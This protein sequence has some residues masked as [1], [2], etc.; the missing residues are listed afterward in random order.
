MFIHLKNIADALQEYNP[1]LH[2]PAP[3]FCISGYAA[4]RRAKRPLTPH[5]LYIAFNWQQA[6]EAGLTPCSNVVILEKSDTTV[7]DLSELLGAKVNFILIRTDHAQDVYH[8][9]EDFFFDICS[10]GVFSDS[11]LHSLFEETGIQSMI[12]QT[13]P[14]FGNPIMVFDTGFHLIAATWQEARK[15][16]YGQEI[17]EQGKLPDHLYTLLNHNNHFHERMRKS[18]VPLKTYFPELGFEQML[19]AIDTQKNM[20]Y[21]VI[22]AVNRPFAPLDAP[23]LYLLKEAINQQM[24]KD[25]FIRNSKGF[26]YEY[27]LKDLLDGKIAVDKDNLDTFN[28]TSSEFQGLLYCLTVETARSASTLN[29]WHIRNEFEIHFPSCKT[30]IYNGEIIVLFTKS[31]YVPFTDEDY[32]KIHA[33]CKEHG[34]YA[35]ISNSF[36]QVTEIHSYYSQSL[37]AIEIGMCQRTSPGLFIYEDY[38]QQHLATIFAQKESLQ[39]FCHPIMKYLMRYDGEHHTDFACSLYTYLIHERN[40]SA[41]AEDLGLHR[42][43]LVYRLKKLEEL[44][45]I[46][47]EDPKLRQYLILSYQM[48]HPS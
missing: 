19:C 31:D 3:E 37:R 13:Y 7:P 24:K 6:M 4:I 47:Y 32:H 43:T 45:K 29:F 39:T 18:D 23:M 26:H 10:R 25:E 15:T 9:I 8:T 30:L 40:C 33:L 42:N 41:A 35:G 27:F 28:Y 14:A 20:G 1:V 22:N 44:V 36:E 2:E 48:N 5:Y 12:D 21:I 11:L 46:D 38:F 17:M 16:K 34:I